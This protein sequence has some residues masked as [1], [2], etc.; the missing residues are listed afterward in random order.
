[1]NRKII[2]IGREYG[3]GGR[4]IA[5]RLAAL[6]GV[7]F[8][9][10]NLIEMAAKE[11]G[12]SEDFIR[13]ANMHRATGSFLYDLYFSSKNLPI[14]D[15]VYMAES[16]IIRKVAEQGPCV[17]VGRCAN[18][19]LRERTDCLHLFF[20]APLE[21]RIRRASEEYKLEGSPEQVR[22]AVI[23]QDKSRASYYNYFSAGRWGDCHDYDMTI[24]TGIGL[25][26]TMDMLLNLL[27]KGD[28]R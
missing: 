19:V 3:S 7:P 25:E 22:A 14:S 1:M 15:Q 5:D 16:E 18:Y 4:I 12:L 20:H 26:E 21:E 2:T 11:S 13:K 10:R 27:G 28:L 23:K 9:D 8:Y 17:I 24:N 6:L